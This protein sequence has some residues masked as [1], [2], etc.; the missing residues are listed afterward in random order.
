MMGVKRK[1]GEYIQNE[2]GIA[3]NVSLVAPKSIPRSTKGKIQ[4]VI[5]KRNLH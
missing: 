2:I 1:I 5:D 3:V 4:R